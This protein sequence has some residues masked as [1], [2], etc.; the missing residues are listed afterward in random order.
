MKKLLAILSLTL[1]SSAFASGFMSLDVDK[2]NGL[3]GSKDSLAQYV[4]AGKSFGD[5]QMGLQSR[6]AQIRDGGGLV[7]SVEV[8]SS[9]KAVSLLGITPFVGVGYDNGFNGATNKSFQYGLLGATMAHKVGP[10]VALLGAK[11]RAGTTEEGPR[12]KQTV[13]FIT[14]SIP[15]TK[16]VSLNLNA[17]RSYETIKET[18][19]GVG[20]GFK[21]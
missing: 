2:V 16:T 5:V 15:V 18:A 7:N 17:S 20:L 3:G 11:T 19:Y 6:T 21:F 8:T 1:T 9:H 12:T 10:G 13:A 14:Y 4:R